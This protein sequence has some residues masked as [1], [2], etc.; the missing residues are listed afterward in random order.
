MAVTAE[1]G[2]TH[3]ASTHTR[4]H[5]DA[6][7]VHLAST[8]TWVCGEAGSATVTTHTWVRRHRQRPQG[9]HAHLG[10]PSRAGQLSAHAQLIKYT[11]AMGAASHA[12]QCE[13]ASIPGDSPQ[14]GYQVNKQSSVHPP[15]GLCRA[16]ELPQ[17]Y[18][19]SAAPS[20]PMHPVVV[21]VVGKLGWMDL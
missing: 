13:A 10:P 16:T 2:S 18:R 6:G 5:A 15:T 4:V 3:T 12:H 20:S 11:D 7:S 17:G 21:N 1:A 8:H 14:P 9:I 19:A